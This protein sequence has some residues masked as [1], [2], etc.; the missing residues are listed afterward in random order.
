METEHDRFETPF[1]NLIVH[2]GMPV[3]QKIEYEMA[4][5]DKKPGNYLFYLYHPTLW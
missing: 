2:I 3:N 1:W 5:N 4:Y